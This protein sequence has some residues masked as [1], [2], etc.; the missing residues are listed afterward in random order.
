MSPAH[1]SS[2]ETHKTRHM[3]NFLVGSFLI[4]RNLRSDVHAYY[5]FARLADDIADH[6]ELSTELKLE[7]LKAME[8]ALHGDQG[9]REILDPAQFGAAAE[10]GDQLNS[11][12]L[13]HRLASDLL[14]AFRWDAENNVCRTWGDLINYC[15]FSACPVGRFLLALHGEINGKEESDALCTALQI[16][17][18]LQDAKDDYCR[19]KRLYVPLDWLEHDNSS[20]KDLTKTTI[21]LELKIVFDRVLNQIEILLTRA[22][23]LPQRTRHRG[24]AAE[25]AMCLSLAY[26]LLRRLQENDPIAFKI[27][28]KKT[29]WIKAGFSGLYRYCL[30]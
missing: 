18:H 24:L 6:S 30:S 19:L 26:S 15:R 12:D 5:R 25:T 20:P 13:D 21:S 27:K 28:L 11:R 10:L 8:A 2:L 17:N 7:Q 22:V 4:P 29:D 3:E 14:E 16:L 9:S 1:A 23:G